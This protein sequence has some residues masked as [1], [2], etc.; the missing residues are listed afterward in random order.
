MKSLNNDK[1][2]YLPDGQNIVESSKSLKELLNRGVAPNFVN[3]T[4]PAELFSNLS[5]IKTD[6]CALDIIM[7]FGMNQES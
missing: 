1:S 7:P 4:Y 5:W 6:A 2:N 3:K